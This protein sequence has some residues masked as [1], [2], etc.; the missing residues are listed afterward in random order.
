MTNSNWTKEDLEQYKLAIEIRQEL[1][2]S[3]YLEDD[4]AIED[5]DGT[6]E[7]VSDPNQIEQELQIFEEFINKRFFNGELE[8][9]AED[10]K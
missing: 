5:E 8:A 2:N 4:Q 7:Y 10:E 6:C 1:I 3:Y 9:Y